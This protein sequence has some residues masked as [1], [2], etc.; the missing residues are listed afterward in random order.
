MELR[1]YLTALR[2]YWA[3]WV[4]VTLAALLVALTVVLV[5][6][7]S[8]QATASVFVAA[9]SGDSTSGAQFIRQRVTSYP[10][11]ARSQAVLGAVIE[12]GDLPETVAQLRTK[13]SA[14][15]PLDSSQIDITVT[16]GDPVRAATITNAVAEEF[17]SVVE[18]LERPGDGDTPVDLTVT[19]PATVPSAPVFPVPGLL[20]GLGLVVGLALGAAA[21]VLRSRTDTRVHTAEDVRAAWGD[22]DL[23]VHATPGRRGSGRLSPQPATLVARRLAAAAEEGP[24]RVLVLGSSPHDDRL[25]RSLAEEVAGELVA[26]GVPAELSGP[27]SGAPTTGSRPAGVQLATGTPLAPLHEWR[28]IGREYDG[29]VVVAEP[30]RAD[31]A[32]LQEVRSILAAAGARPLAVVLAPRRRRR[33]T[34]GGARKTVPARAPQETARPRTGQTAL[35][36]R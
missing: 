34:A 22:R 15:N 21:A 35:T 23:P 24:A 20:L 25:A 1:D 11:V 17:G 18:Q 14:S 26:G 29:V 10:D 4:G 2:R 16:D 9:T 6:S 32:D 28:R 19:D 8:Y 7:P 5:S 31:R 36:G 12:E 33:D 3:T 30:G 27:V 13:I